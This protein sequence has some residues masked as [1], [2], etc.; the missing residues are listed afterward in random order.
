MHW[1]HVCQQLEGFSEGL[2]Q[3]EALDRKKDGTRVL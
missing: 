1:Q 3:M 2:D